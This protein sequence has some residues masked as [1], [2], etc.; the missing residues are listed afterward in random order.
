MANDR[1]NRAARRTPR[2]VEEPSL[3]E[4]YRVWIISGIAAAVVLVAIAIIA[5]KA[6]GGGSKSSTSA[7]NQP[8]QQGAGT[9]IVAAIAAI[10]ATTFDAV[11]TGSYQGGIA[12]AA[13]V[14]RER[15]AGRLLLRRGVVPLLR[16]RTLGAGGGAG[17][18]R[19]VR[20]RRP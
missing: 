17:P 3:I 12:P 8:A 4:R 11:G 10:P 1:R 14:D 5:I 16:R 6:T 9:S 18:L 13:A 2:V 19:H 15:Q 20:Q 7:E